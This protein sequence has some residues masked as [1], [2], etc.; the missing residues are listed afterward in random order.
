MAQ[1][2]KG[3]KKYRVR[4]G[5]VVMA[6]VVLVLVTGLI[7]FLCVRFGKNRGN[8]EAER[9]TVDYNA[10]VPD[11][12]FV[13]IEL[14]DC[15]MYVGSTFLLT[16]T[17]NPDEYAANVIWSS[18][19]P[20]V[21]YVDG[22]GR[23]TVKGT[24]TAAI[25]ATYDVLADSVVI[26]GVDREQPVISEELPVYDVIDEQIVAVQPPSSDETSGGGNL[27]D[28]HTGE[29]EGSTETVPS[30][31]E[32]QG[33]TSGG[34]GDTPDKETQQE[35]NAYEIITE[36]VRSSGFETYLDNTYIYREDGNYLGEVIVQ[37]NMTQIYVMTRTTAMDS[38][39]KHIVK[40]LIP[41]EYENVFARFVSASEDQTFSADGVRVRIV[42]PTG[43]G[44]TQLII[45]Y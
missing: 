1:S 17:S 8:I 33:E 44:H 29:T 30:Q 26:C 32:G 16:C 7:V 18:S 27:P 41:T 24:G 2:S 4:K 14:D 9:E 5:R 42:A 11:G 28:N 25:T 13:Q 45:Y 43:G 39:F 22:K 35:D 6:A 15:N 20:D 34:E 37:E 19:D 21:V 38:A 3:R 31:T 23:I 36:A 40:S 10:V 12:E